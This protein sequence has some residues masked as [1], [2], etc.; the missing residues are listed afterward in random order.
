[1][2]MVRQ[3]EHF[4]ESFL[5]LGEEQGHFINCTLW[6]EEKPL[7]ALTLIQDQL[8]SCWCLRDIL[9]PDAVAYVLLGIVN[10]D[11]MRGNSSSNPGCILIQTDRLTLAC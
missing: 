6:N 2:Q 1:M 10:E 11:Y 7:T 3:E 8:L 4:T 9:R 5:S